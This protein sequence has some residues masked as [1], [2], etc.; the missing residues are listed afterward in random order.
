M[1]AIATGHKGSNV[2][3]VNPQLFNEK[4]A[5]FLQN[6][7]KIEQPNWADLVKTGCLNQ[8]PPNLTNWWYTRAAAVF[9]QVYLHPNTSVTELRNRFGSKKHYGTKPCHF[10]QSSGKVLR[11]ILQ[12]LEKAG[13]IKTAEDDHGGRIVTANGQKQLDLIAVEIKK[14]QQ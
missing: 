6:S 13:Y 2:R 11:T 10:C 8:M 1:I 3:E 5:Q 14:S 7:K 4:L 12:Q 9:R